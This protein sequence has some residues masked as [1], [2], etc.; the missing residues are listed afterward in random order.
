MSDQPEK[1]FGGIVEFWCIHE[2]R[3]H[4]SEDIIKEKCATDPQF[5]TR[6]FTGVLVEDKLRRWRPGTA[7]QSSTIQHFD[8]ESLVVETRNTMYQLSGPGRFT[9]DRPQHY[10]EEVGKTMIL[11]SSES[12]LTLENPG[13]NELFYPDDKNT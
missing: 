11:L 5:G 12:N 8:K 9:N 1:P 7:M 13:N 4:I 10:G 6:L 2:L 3:D